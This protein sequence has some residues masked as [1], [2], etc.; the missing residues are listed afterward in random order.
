MAQFLIFVRTVVNLMN[1]EDSDDESV[2][3]VV[4]DLAGD[5]GKSAS[6]VSGKASAMK[7]FDEFLTANFS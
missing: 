2:C 6:T 4:Y 3:G 7:R 1:D 5:G